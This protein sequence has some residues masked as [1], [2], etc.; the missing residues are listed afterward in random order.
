NLHHV[1]D[2]IDHS[3][4]GALSDVKHH[5]HGEVVVF[6]QAA[7]EAQAQIDDG[8]DGAAQIHDALDE[9]PCIGDARG[10][11]IPTDLLHLQDVDAVRFLAQTEGEVLPCQVGLHIEFFHHAHVSLLLAMCV[12]ASVARTAHQA[13]HVQDQ[14]H[15]PVAH[16]GRARHVIDLAVIAFQVLDHHLLLAEQLVH[17]Q[18]HAT[19]LG[20]DHHHDGAGGLVESRHL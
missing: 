16:D 2:R 7:V 4:N 19:V 17:Q 14:G 10:Q 13:A 12:R 9:G 18:G 3:A 20:L 11:F 8:D 5:G 15:A 6:D 1:T